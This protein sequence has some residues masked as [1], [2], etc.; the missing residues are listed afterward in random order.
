MADSPPAAKRAAL[1]GELTRD[2]EEAVALAQGGG[3]LCIVGKSGVG[4]TVTLREIVNRLRARGRKVEVVAFCGSAASAAGGSTIH[5]WLGIGG[6]D[7]A[8]EVEKVK[9]RLTD[10][11]R[12]TR[13]FSN[14]PATNDWV[15]RERERLARAKGMSTVVLDELSMTPPSMLV[16]L[17][18]YL[19]AARNDERPFGGVQF[20]AVGDPCQLPPVALK[21]EESSYVFDSPLWAACKFQTAVLGT[22][23]RQTDQLFVRVLD[24][25]RQ[26]QR[27]PFREWPEDL[28]A[29]LLARVNAPIL[30]ESGAPFEGSALHA[31]NRDVDRSNALRLARLEGEA[32]TYEP[33]VTA[34]A[35]DGK[36]QEGGA[37]VSEATERE[38]RHGQAR[39]CQLKPGARVTLT[40]NV[41]V[42]RGLFNGSVGEVL[43][44]P[45]DRTASVRFRCGPVVV[46]RVTADRALADGGK[47]NVN[48]MPLRVANA[49]TVHKS[50]GLTMDAAVVHLEPK[51][52]PGSSYTALS[53]V[54]SLDAL[55]I[56]VPED[57]DPAAVFAAAFL[58]DKR[59]LAFLDSIAPGDDE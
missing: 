28:R 37:E 45:D 30:D 11:A 41:D 40:Y 52:Q 5:S 58:T 1:G 3:N 16:L 43:T 13:R 15:R 48:F 25:V 6:C 32:R 17:D 23:M 2:Q 51:M 14:K 34:T 49:A 9:Q 44:V 26:G 36:P 57:H 39:D 24:A 53:R 42:A 7:T 55:S 38:R 33:R 27:R 18:A 10:N 29:A 31:T 59:A 50:Q 19:R 47:L 12:K 20:I 46:S 56:R 54:R 4:K 21:G 35:R 8:E 22:V